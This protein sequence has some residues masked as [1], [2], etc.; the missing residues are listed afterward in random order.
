MEAASACV[1][2]RTSSAEA[3][4]PLARDRVLR[5]IPNL[6]APPGSR[7]CWTKPPSCRSTRARDRSKAGGRDGPDISQLRLDGDEAGDPQL[8]MPGRAR[9]AAEGR[10]DKEPQNDGGGAGRGGAAPG[11]GIG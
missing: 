5:V 9:R 2:L 6:V 11:Q 4:R 8:E 1:R 10:R 3:G 7:G